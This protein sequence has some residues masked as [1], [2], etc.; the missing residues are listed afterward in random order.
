M[1]RSRSASTELPS[2]STA[3]R[4][5][6]FGRVARKSWLL[7]EW[8]VIRLR[9]EGEEALTTWI[10]DRYDVPVPGHNTKNTSNIRFWSAKPISGFDLASFSAG[11]CEFSERVGRG[12]WMS[13]D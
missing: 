8:L 12:T 4:V 11:D 9:Q 10:E 6:P 7:R 5:K 3:T 13:G 1:S 2:A